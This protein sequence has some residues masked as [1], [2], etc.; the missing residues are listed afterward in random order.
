MNRR[1]TPTGSEVTQARSKGK[2]NVHAIVE[3][4]SGG[5]HFSAAALQRENTTVVKLKEELDEA[6][7]K[8]ME[9]EEQKHESHLA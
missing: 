1:W 5:G 4:M 2:I 6:L 7:R 9:E 8:Y 3:T